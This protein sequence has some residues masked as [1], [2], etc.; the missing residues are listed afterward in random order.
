ME[1]LWGELKKKINEKVEDSRKI[2]YEELRNM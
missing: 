1:D 2:L